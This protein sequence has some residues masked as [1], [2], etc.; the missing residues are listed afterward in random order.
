MTSEVRLGA[1]ENGQDEKKRPI[2]L[3]IWCIMKLCPLTVIAT[4]STPSRT[5][6]SPHCRQQRHMLGVCGSKQKNKDETLKE[7]MYRKALGSLKAFC[8]EDEGRRAGEDEGRRAGDGDRAENV[9]L[10]G[11]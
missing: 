11:W 2:I 4:Y 7:V 1:G 5:N 10:R 9:N 3:R 6:G 8:C